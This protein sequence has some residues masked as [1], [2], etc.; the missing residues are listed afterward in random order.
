M[1]WPQRVL[2]AHKCTVTNH[3]VNI[4]DVVWGSVL[5][6]GVV[7]RKSSLACMLCS[8]VDQAGFTG[9]LLLANTAVSVMCRVCVFNRVTCFEPNLH[10]VNN[11]SISD[12]SM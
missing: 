9:T 6:F 3:A 12:W 8:L 11:L 10:H 2:E 4:A 1:L 7:D 5:G